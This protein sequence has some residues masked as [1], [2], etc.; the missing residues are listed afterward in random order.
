MRWASPRM[1]LEDNVCWYRLSPSFACPASR[2]LAAGLFAR[3]HDPAGIV[4]VEDDPVRVL[5]LS[6]EPFL[7]FLAEIEEKLSARRFDCRLLCLEI[8]GLKAKMV[9][10]DERIWVLETGADLALV[11]QQRQI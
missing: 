6:L 7:P 10:A 4:D 11:L 3:C 8:V 9:Q 2:R 5:E 1:T